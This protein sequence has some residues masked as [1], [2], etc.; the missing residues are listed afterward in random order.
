MTRESIVSGIIGSVP[1]QLT[2]NE[3]DSGKILRSAANTYQI[4]DVKRGGMGIVYL[5]NLLTADGQEIQR[6]GEMGGRGSL[7][8][9]TFSEQFFFDQRMIA[10]FRNELFIWTRL[11]QVPFVVPAFNEEIIDGRPHIV[12]AVI[13]PDDAGRVS[14][15]DHIASA[16][17]GLPAATCLR[18]A[19]GVAFGMA[20]ASKL[21]PGLVHS[22]I[23]PS[24][25]LLWHDMPMIA[26]FGLARVGQTLGGREVSG[27]PEYLAP[28]C[29]PAEG[30]R[31]NGPGEASDIYAFGCT[32]LEALT[33]TPPFSGDLEALK[34][35]HHSGAPASVLQPNADALAIDLERLARRCIQTEPLARPASFSHIRAELEE[36]GT[37]FAADVVE[38]I[39][40]L[41][42]DVV[43]RAAMA[44]TS[45][46]RMNSMLAR[47]DY[48]GAR[49]LLEEIPAD[50]FR[51]ADLITAGS[52]ASQSG[53]DELALRF[54]AR[55]EA[56]SETASPDDRAFCANETGLSLARLERYE[57]AIATYSRGLEFASDEWQ[58]SL[59]GNRAM[60][61]L[62]LNDTEAA[63]RSL[64]Q[65]LR[66]H[67][68]R[69]M[70]WGQLAQVKIAQQ[71]AD[72]AEDAIRRAISL[73]PRNGQFRMVLA[74]I[75]MDL[76][77][78]I[79]AAVKT[80]DIAYNLGAADRKWARRMM[81]CS[82][83][84]DKIDVASG[85]LAAVTR[86]AGEA[87]AMAFFRKVLEDARKFLEVTETGADDAIRDLVRAEEQLAA[88]LGAV[89]I[90]SNASGDGVPTSADGGSSSTGQT[91]IRRES[92]ED[93]DNSDEPLSVK[94]NNGG[95]FL[96]TNFFVQESMYCRDFYCLHEDGNF[97]D[98]CVRAIRQITDFQS[99]AEFMGNAESRGRAYA[100]C[101]CPSC[102]FAILTNRD[103]GESLACRLC[104]AKH[105]VAYINEPALASLA[106]QVNEA[107]GLGV[108]Q[109]ARQGLLLL[110]GFWPANDKQRACIERE[111][112]SAGFVQLSDAP[113]ARL[114]LL[115]GA[116]DRGLKWEGDPSVW[117]KE[118]SETDSGTPPASVEKALRMIRR[119]VGETASMSIIVLP[120]FAPLLTT[121]KVELEKTLLD[122][123]R[124]EFW[125][126]PTDTEGARRL[127]ETLIRHKELDEARQVLA[128]T[129]QACRKPDEDP[130]LLVAAAAIAHAEGRLEDADR[131]FG[132]AVT[133]APRDQL[134]RLRRL[135]VLAEIGDETRIQPVRSE[136]VAHGDPMSAK[137]PR[138]D[139]PR[140]AVKSASRE[141]TSNDVGEEHLIAISVLLGAA[142][143]PEHRQKFEEHMQ[144]A[145]RLV[146]GYIEYGIEPRIRLIERTWAT[147]EGFK[148]LVQDSAGIGHVRSDRQKVL[149][150]AGQKA[151]FEVA[152]DLTARYYK[153]FIETELRDLLSQI[154]SDLRNKKG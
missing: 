34:H 45:G 65:L 29:W 115:D 60:S 4:V 81:I 31:A 121:G 68:G 117:V 80:L 40:L 124:E 146:K 14:L 114:Y 51:G 27:T 10:A 128:T 69:P 11:K 95:C 58:A 82:L 24:N 92:D 102:N 145:H 55:F 87:E 97:V 9:K 96:N 131:L 153:N 19:L 113:G 12:M 77:K 119:E 91:G 135:R 85:I 67:S 71:Q 30:G 43:L 44:E 122:S 154:K 138:A 13:P 3:S 42:S 75:Q 149:D 139:A 89:E 108:E 52:T 127:V 112:N 143:A 61:Q 66:K 46:E 147:L 136:Y 35:A 99:S 116:R 84:T 78:D 133:R 152:V 16:P 56:E 23:K 2:S 18:V 21:E 151:I 64:Q 101:R 129:R 5:C 32:L 50:A 83:L 90:A 63:G 144:Q 130:N 79:H 110:V 37:R 49:R 7:A 109:A 106:D 1:D 150:E 48:A 120:E 53:D 142:D 15:A 100:F 134:A 103:P 6:T 148:K 41:A 38:Q 22:D 123:L 70:L 104:G 57:E 107:L 62:K 140:R 33:G 26:D 141:S 73:D 98:R 94:I 118:A 111:M 72:E 125:A 137:W 105:P 132:N 76:R 39:H 25:I 54:F 47:G 8:L 59:V 126:S 17:D 86:D 88:S 20:E 28:E 36:I 93:E 74:E